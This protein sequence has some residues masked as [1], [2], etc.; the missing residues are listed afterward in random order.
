MV[1]LSATG[2]RSRREFDTN[3]LPV[4]SCRYDQWLYEIDPADDRAQLPDGTLVYV[5]STTFQGDGL[6][7]LALAMDPGT[8][9]IR[10]FR[11][12]ERGTAGICAGST[13]GSGYLTCV[14]DEQVG[15]LEI[16][17]IAR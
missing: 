5:L 2:R 16:E 15:W 7:R 8:N 3:Y 10:T 11:A 4:F 12:A 1:R 6:Y 17:D 14:G 9:V 13:G